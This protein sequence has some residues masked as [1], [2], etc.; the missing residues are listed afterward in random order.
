MLFMSTTHVK[1]V[2]TG[3]IR[4]RKAYKFGLFVYLSVER[5]FEKR[6]YQTSFNPHKRD[7]DLL[8]NSCICWKPV[9]KAD[10]QDLDFT[11]FTKKEI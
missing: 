10:M 4:L 2:P 11:L 9:R 6:V 1:L 3:R 5:E 7:P 8:L